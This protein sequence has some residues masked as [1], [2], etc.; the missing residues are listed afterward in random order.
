MKKLEEN[1]AESKGHLRGS[2]CFI[3]S[4]YILILSQR[5]WFVSNERQ[6]REWIWKR[7]ERGETGSS[8]M[9]NSN[10]DVLLEE[11][12]LYRI[13]GKNNME[14]FLMLTRFVQ[15]RDLR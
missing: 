9:G 15:Y 12:N 11:R 4:C 7:G 13:K 2:F 1:I 10:Q 6:K 8:R 5:S 14:K 3:L